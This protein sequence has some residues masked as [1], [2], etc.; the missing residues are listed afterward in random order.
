M[1]RKQASHLEQIINILGERG[2]LRGWTLVPIEN[3]SETEVAKRLREAFVFL[4]TCHEEGFGLPAAEAG[5]SG[6]L[7]VGY[8]GGAAEEY[9]VEGLAERVDQDDILE[10]A[11]SA[12]KILGLVERNEDAALD[13]GR[14]FSAFLT[15]RYSFAREA[16]S[17]LSAWNT[18]LGKV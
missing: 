8:T 2:A 16:E 7:V 3:M 6:C 13:R 5:M 17:V 14:A 11:I 4:S 10:F 15:E 18:L 1:P 9:F 12:E